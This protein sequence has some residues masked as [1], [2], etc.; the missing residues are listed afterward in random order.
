[1]SRYPKAKRGDPLNF[2]AQLQNDLIDLLGAGQTGQALTTISGAASQGVVVRVRNT[3]SSA[4]A[5]WDC[6]S[7]TT[8]LRFTI[9]TAGRESVIFN[10]EAANADR[11]AAILQEPIAPNKYGRALI[12]GYTLAKVQTATSATLLAARPRPATHNLEATGSGSIRLL[13]APSTTAA[14][15]RPVIIGA[16]DSTFKIYR[17]TLTADMGTSAT[18]NVVEQ[19]GSET[20]NGVTL[21]DPIGLAAWQVTGGLGLCWRGGNGQYYVIVPECED[22]TP[23]SGGSS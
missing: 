9:G 14:S 4:R 1:M 10:A 15:V 8:T 20:A 12:F 16:G 19:G 5:R 23:E 21:N 17:Y 6:M 18:A 3:T 11:P 2:P 13:A 22:D 7:L